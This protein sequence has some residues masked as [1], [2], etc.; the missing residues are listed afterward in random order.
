MVQRIAGAGK[1]YKIGLEL[2]IS[3]GGRLIPTLKDMGKGVFLDLKL[4]DI[5]NTVKGALL[6]SLKLGADIIN[7]HI[8]GGR[9]ML[10]LCSDT[11]GEYTAKNGSSQKII[12]VT[13]LTS[14]SENYLLDYGISAE[15]EEYVLKLAKFAKDAGLDGVVASA[16]E[17]RKIK[18]QCG[19]GFITV[20]PGI[21]FN[22]GLLNDQKRAVTPQEAVRSGTDYIVVG[23]PITCSPDPVRAAELFNSALREA[24]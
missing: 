5:P 11:C 21:R 24:I 14:L 7:V 6:A 8:Q 19:E 17:S 4:H 13:L 1:F 15:P 9:E 22:D 18:E 10:M 2:F 3:G 20:T 12:G 23:R 16:R